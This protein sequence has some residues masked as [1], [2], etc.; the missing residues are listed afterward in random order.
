MV[1]I[2]L[3][4]IPRLQYEQPQREGARGSIGALGAGGLGKFQSG[5]S[6]YSLWGRSLPRLGCDRLT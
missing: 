4:S 2:G 3:G 1:A 5:L 6:V